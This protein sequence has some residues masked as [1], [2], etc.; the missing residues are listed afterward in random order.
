[1]C[2]TGGVVAT[3]LLSAHAVVSRSWEVNLLLCARIFKPSQ[4]L[5]PVITVANRFSPEASQG[6]NAAIDEIWSDVIFF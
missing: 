4:S 6:G 5:A 2:Q 3:G 1:M